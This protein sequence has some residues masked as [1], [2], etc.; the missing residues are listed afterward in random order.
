M[1]KDGLRT[2]ASNGLTPERVILGL[3]RLYLENSAFEGVRDSFA[4]VFF[5]VADAT[6]RYLTYANAGHEP[7]A[8]ID[9]DGTVVVL[10]PTS[11]L[12]G[13]FDGQF[14]L[15]K[16]GVMKLQPGALLVATTDGVTEARNRTGEHFGMERLIATVLPHRTES[17]SDIA[18]AL[19]A[20]VQNFSHDSRHDD[21]A[22]L[23]VR[24]TK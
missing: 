21:V 8:V 18:Q 12:I 1:L 20:E 11:P 10:G 7:V 2:L 3:N 5:G 13:V 19:L 22:I 23:V 16:Q 17:E 4:T 9:P 6:R 24:F 15:F 14:H